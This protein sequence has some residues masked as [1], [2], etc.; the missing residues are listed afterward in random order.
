MQA[1]DPGE[2]DDVGCRAGGTVLDRAAERRVLADAEVGPVLIVV[3]DVYRNVA[4]TP[5]VKVAPRSK[6]M[7]RGADSNGKA[8]RSRC[9]TQP[10]VGLDVT[11]HRTTSR[12]PWRMMKSTWKTRNVA[13]GTE[14]KS[15][16]AIP[17]RWFRRNVVQVC[18]ALGARGRE[19]K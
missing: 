9:A 19:R 8:S 4:I 15:M 12:R 13:V 18:P 10:A 16:A 7:N 17:F 6:I 5:S 11:A 3:V 1:A 14:K 2:A